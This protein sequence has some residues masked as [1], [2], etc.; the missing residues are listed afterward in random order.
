MCHSGRRNTGFQLISV[1]GNR[2]SMNINWHFL[3]LLMSTLYSSFLYVW[4]VFVFLPLFKWVIFCLFVSLFCFVFCIC[5]V[6]LCFLFFLVYCC[7]CFLILF[8][9]DFCSVLCFF[10]HTN[11]SDASYSYF[12]CFSNSFVCKTTFQILVIQICKSKMDS[13]Y[14]GKKN[15]T[16]KT[17]SERQ[18]TRQKTD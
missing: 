18:N 6:L 9:F 2:K 17:S 11:I 1:L 10:C 14:N 16:K 12:F 4:F 13:Q 8:S 3:Y 7:F 5:F 15:Q